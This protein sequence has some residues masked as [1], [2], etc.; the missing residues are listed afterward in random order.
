MSLYSGRQIQAK[1]KSW[2]PHSLSDQ[3]ENTLGKVLEKHFGESSVEIGCRW[4][5]GKGQYT[6]V[7]EAESLYRQ[8]VFYIGAAHCP[9]PLCSAGGQHCPEVSQVIWNC[10]RDLTAGLRAFSMSHNVWITP[11]NDRAPYLRNYLYTYCHFRSF[12]SGQNLDLRIWFYSLQNLGFGTKP[13]PHMVYTS[14]LC[15]ELWEQLY[16]NA[17]S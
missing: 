10:S 1:I 7:N 8:E 13:C 17:F 6:A 15:L 3:K 12:P 2:S 4:S 9:P 5:R 11:W 14:A 16:L